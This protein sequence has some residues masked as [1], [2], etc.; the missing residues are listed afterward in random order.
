ME[1]LSLALKDKAERIELRKAG[2]R[3]RDTQ[4][5]MALDVGLRVR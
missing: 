5:Q 3:G 1:L 2:F 4:E